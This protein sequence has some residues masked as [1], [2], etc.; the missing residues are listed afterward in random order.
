MKMVGY[1][2][3]SHKVSYKDANIIKDLKVEVLV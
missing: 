3:L 2:F 1:S